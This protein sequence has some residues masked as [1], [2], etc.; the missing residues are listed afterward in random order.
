MEA[1]DRVV[2]VT[3]GTYERLEREAVRRGMSPD[4]LADELLSAALPVTL[5]GEKPGR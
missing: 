3:P 4:A 1:R 5:S 2:R